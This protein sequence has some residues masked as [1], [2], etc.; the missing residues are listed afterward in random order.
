RLNHNGGD[1][2][3]VRG[4]LMVVLMVWWLRCGDDSDDED[5][6]D[7]WLGDTDGKDDHGGGVGGDVG[8]VVV[9]AVETVA[10]RGVGDRIDRVT[11]NIFGFAEN[12]RRKSFPTTAAENGVGWLADCHNMTPFVVEERGLKCY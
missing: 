5:G 9:W 8:E 4:V 7:E 1:E 6:G 10:A 12:D 2:M 3:V 11:G